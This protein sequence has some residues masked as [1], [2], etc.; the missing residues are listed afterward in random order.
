MKNEKD[1]NKY[2]KLLGKLTDFLTKNVKEIKKLLNNAS[3]V[4]FSAKDKELNK[5]ADELLE[6]LKKEHKP[7]IKA[8]E[9]KSA[10]DSW[11]FTV[12]SA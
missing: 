8:F 10:K 6:S 4:A 7:L 5:E 2:I 11:K 1:T 9:P 12:I 3:Y